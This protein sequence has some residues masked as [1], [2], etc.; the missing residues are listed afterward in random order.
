[1]A[2]GRSRRRRPDMPHLV[3]K[4]GI[5]IAVLGFLAA[6]TWLWPDSLPG[7]IASGLIAILALARLGG[8]RNRSR[9]NDDLR[10][11][12]LAARSAAENEVLSRDPRDILARLGADTRARIDRAEGA[13]IAAGIDCGP[14]SFTRKRKPSRR[15]KRRRR[16]PSISPSPS[17]CKPPS[18]RNAAAR[19]NCVS[20]TRPPSSPRGK[21]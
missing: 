16:R 11:K 8:A 18:P 21:A 10:K 14:K 7:R 20:R 6:A 15:H 5:A 3:T 9:R 17:P 13:G 2:F 1:M 12:A 4:A 19:R